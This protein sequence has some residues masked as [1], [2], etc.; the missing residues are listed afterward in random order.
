MKFFFWLLF[1]GALQA[2]STSS[3]IDLRQISIGD[4]KGDVLHQLGNPTRSYYK[5]DTQRWV[6]K[7]RDEGQTFVEKEVWFK[8]GRVVYVDSHKYKAP[9][10]AKKKIEYTPIE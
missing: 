2:C 3:P 7:L 10:P 9:A 1:C 8:D 5:E 6:Y 4:D